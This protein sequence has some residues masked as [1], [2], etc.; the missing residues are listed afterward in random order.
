MRVG[1]KIQIKS[2]KKIMRMTVSQMKT[3]MKLIQSKKMRSVMIIRKL[4]LMIIQMSERKLCAQN[5]KSLYS[6][7]QTGSLNNLYLRLRYLK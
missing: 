1:T 4:E 6:L 5:S 3:R 2:H 7:A